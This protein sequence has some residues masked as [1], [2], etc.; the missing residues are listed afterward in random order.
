M[1]TR[2]TSN[3]MINVIRPDLTDAIPYHDSFEKNVSKKKKMKM[4]MKRKYIFPALKW[5]T[6]KSVEN[7]KD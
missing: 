5:L 4:K 7:T 3:K 1:C 6:A 2:P